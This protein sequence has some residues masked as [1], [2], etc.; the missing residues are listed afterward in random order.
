MKHHP[1]LDVKRTVFALLLALGLLGAG[2]DDSHDIDH[3]PPSGM[4]SIV[5]DNRTAYDIRVY[6]D[7]QEQPHASDDDWQAYDRAP[8]AYRVV[9]D[10][11]DGWRSF[12]SD[13]DVLSNRL[14]VLEVTID[15]LRSSAYDVLIYFD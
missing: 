11:D 9:L 4:G 6:I 7:G 5:V 2:C 13:V 14:T 1:A 12:S 3:N 10:E 8:G 15:P